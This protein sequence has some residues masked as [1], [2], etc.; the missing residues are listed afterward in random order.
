M[1][2]C[3]L[4]PLTTR[5]TLKVLALRAFE[6]GAFALRSSL[7]SLKDPPAPEA[8]NL[9]LCG[10]SWFSNRTL[11]L[12]G[13]PRSTD[14]V[15]DDFDAAGAAVEFADLPDIV[16]FNSV[17]P[18]V[19]V[20]DLLRFGSSCSSEFKFVLDFD[21]MLAFERI[22]GGASAPKS[23]PM[24]GNPLAFLV[25]ARGGSSSTPFPVK[26]VGSMIPFPVGVSSTAI[27][28]VTGGVIMF[29]LPLNFSKSAEAA[30]VLFTSPLT[31]FLEILKGSLL[32]GG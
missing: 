21:L 24:P 23:R 27:S 29:L 1:G 2:S 13:A 28:A 32:E 19:V 26:N 7:S 10:L 30:V 9:P 8:A 14:A 22:F 20:E 31:L 5:P 16:R 4:L 6:L 3:F 25:G 18:V 12:W 15:P 17:L 11:F